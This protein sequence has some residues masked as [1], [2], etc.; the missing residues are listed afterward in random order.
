MNVLIHVWFSI[1]D[2]FSDRCRCLY[3]SMYILLVACGVMV[4]DMGSGLGYP[5]SNPVCISM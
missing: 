3:N 2:S 1:N 4:I 5:S